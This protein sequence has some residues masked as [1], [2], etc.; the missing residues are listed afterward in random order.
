[1]AADLVASAGGSDRMTTTNSAKTQS[2]VGMLISEAL[3]PVPLGIALCVGVGASTDRAAGAAW[4]LLAILFTA[5]LP[6]LVTWRARHPGGGSRPSRSVR[7]RYLA[8]TLLSAAVGTTMVALAGAPDRVIAVAT[9]ILIGLATGALVNARWRASNHATA[10]AGGITML[11][12][13][14]GG[15]FLPMYALVG[16]VGWSRVTSGRHSWAEVVAG[17]VLG[18]AVSAIALPLLLGIV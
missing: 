15:W 18:A 10:V 8:M 11:V 5:V 1:V 6:Y 3:G 14:Y 2:R 7:V 9:T 17:A 13:L 12:V 16:L 4:G